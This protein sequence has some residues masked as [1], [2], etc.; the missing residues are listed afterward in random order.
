MLQR[1]G[2]RD[3]HFRHG[4]TAADAH[5]LA[6]WKNEILMFS[7][8][9]IGR[10]LRDKPESYEAEPTAKGPEVCRVQII[11]V[12]LQKPLRIEPLRFRIEVLAV[13][14]GR[15]REE[16]LHSLLHKQAWGYLL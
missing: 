8:L 10:R 12:L 2:G 16:N 7:E 3:L 4:K 14:A 13:V 11:G 15:R 1:L 5:A 6:G 9:D